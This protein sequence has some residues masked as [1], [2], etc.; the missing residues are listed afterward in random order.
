MTTCL[1]F[2]LFV[3]A[4]SSVPV[5]GGQGPGPKPDAKQLE[6]LWDELASDDAAKA[7][8]AMGQM[9]GVPAETTALLKAKLKAV[10]P[11]DPKV[12]QKLLEDLNSDQYT[13]RQK[14]STQLEKL[15]DLAG[16]ALREKLD[17][18]PSLEMRK[19]IEA[20]IDKLDGPV[21]LP[22]LL[23]S[24]RA[25]ELLELIGN[26]AGAGAAGQRS[27]GPPLHRSSPRRGDPARQ[28]LESCTEI[29]HRTPPPPFNLNRRTGVSCVVPS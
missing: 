2:A 10:D 8:K 17:A 25:V 19:R 28:A 12:L 3:L 6:I 5:S 14:A 23:R 20:L 9:A 4:W 7:F 16:P 15:A 13:V 27:A 11:A 18:K 24:L 29:A 26:S 1:S 21:T 22:E